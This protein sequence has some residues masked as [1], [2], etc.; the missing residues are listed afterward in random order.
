MARHDDGPKLPAGGFRFMH[1]L[2]ARAL[3]ELLVD[4]KVIDQTQLET[5]LIYQKAKPGTR[6]G[7]VLQEL[8]YVSSRDFIE[9]LS[10]RM[11]VV[12]SFG[13]S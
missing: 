1:S 2:R 13:G 7:T 12:K 5:A 3:G 10:S 11:P 9:A 4:Q 8:G 6:L